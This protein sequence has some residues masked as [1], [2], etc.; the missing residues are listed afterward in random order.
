MDQVYA[1]IR[2]Y[3]YSYGI[4]NTPVATIKTGSSYIYAK[5]EW[6]NPFGSIK[7]R[8]AYF[9]IKSMEIAG[10]IDGKTIV[11]GTS[12]NT[13]MAVAGISSAMGIKSEIILPSN[14]SEFTK[15]KLKEYGSIVI[16]T[17]PEYGTEASIDMAIKL[18][19]SGDYVYLNQHGSDA[20]TMSHYWTTAPEMFERN[21]VP[22]AIV[23]GVG[24]GGTIT[25]LAKFFKEKNPDVRVIGVQPEDGSR[26]PGLRNVSRASHRGIIDRYGSLIDDFIYVSEKDAVLEVSSYYVENGVLIGVSSGANLHASRIVA[27]RYKKIFTVFPDDGR[28]YGD[29]F[30][31]YG[32]NN[33]LSQKNM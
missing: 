30:N 26:I 15:R 17:P 18:A 13:G 3:A 1:K 28:K 7:D 21:G 11:E 5:E 12:G 16:E 22:D 32:I 25:G 29:I 14:A 10:K 19:R 6:L 4:G 23:V 2:D 31:R 33:D 9:L 24:T 27:G 8:A 20:S